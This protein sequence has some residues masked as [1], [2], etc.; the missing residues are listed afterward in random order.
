MRFNGVEIMSKE[1]REKVA[2]I[3]C[4]ADEASTPSSWM[5]YEGYADEIILLILD[6]VH[7]VIIDDCETADECRDAITNASIKYANKLGGE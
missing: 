4:G 1:L 5:M 2:K 7:D 3:V 6:E